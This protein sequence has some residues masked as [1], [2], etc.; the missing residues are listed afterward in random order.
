MK[1]CLS[2][3]F[4]FLFLFSCLFL[5]RA[6]CAGTD[7][8]S[9]AAPD[10]S[11]TDLNGRR[12]SLSDYKDKKAVVLFF[13]TTWCPYCRQELKKL[14]VEY[15]SLLKD[16][17]AL[18]AINSGEPKEKVEGYAKSRNLSLEI[19]L[20]ENSVVSEKYEVMGVPT[21]FILDK[22]GKIIFSSNTFP[23]DKLKAL[24]AK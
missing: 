3:T 1:K 10:F 23:G 15:P 2:L 19:F 4:I 8:G 13:W 7:S 21:Y 18:L 17:I 6:F 9:S 24:A 14:N 12:V 16:S 11:L 5:C 22:S 20:D